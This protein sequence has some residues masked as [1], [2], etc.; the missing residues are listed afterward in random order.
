MQLIDWIVL[1]GTLTFIVTYGVYKTRN[2]KGAQDYIRGGSETRWW[3]IGL[4]TMATQA[5]AITFLSTPGQAFHDGMG[6]VQ[7]YFGLP[8]AMVIICMFFIPIYRRLNVYTAYEYLESRFDRKTRTL[9]AV[10]FLIQRG[11]AAGL[12]I[13]APAIIL[14]AVLGW[15]LSGLTVLIGSL[16]IIYTVAGGTKAVSVTHKQQMA[17]ILTGMF[18]AFF[19]ILSYLPENINFS[20]A[21]EIAG[22][23]GKMDILDFSFD[24]ENRYTF[25]SGII[26]GSFLALSYFGT[27]QS[28]VQRYLSGRSVNES[29]MGMIMNGMLKVPLQFFILLVGVLVFVFYQFNN[30]P[31]NFNPAATETVL[32]SDY[33]NQY[34]D[35]MLE[36]DEIQQEKQNLHLQFAE[37]NNFTPKNNSTYRE[38]LATLNASENETR[39]KARKLI[40]ASDKDAESNDKDYVFIHFILN[41]L[42]RGLIGLL[43]AVILSAA[44]SSTASE[45]NA[46]SSTTSID[47]YKRSRKTEMSDEHYVKASKWFTLLWGAIAIAFASFANLFDNLIQLVNIIGSIFYG[48]VLGIF[49]LAFFIKIVNS[50][51]VFVAAIITQI[52]VIILYK[53]DVMPYL[54]LNL[55][56]CLLVMALALILELFIKTPEHKIK[57]ST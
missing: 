28:Q 43:L 13:F 57:R 27:D 11:L 15:N 47:L 44:M 39:Q 14:S 49:L 26:G 1:L 7:F 55:V 54:W 56:G 29:R 36:H 21:L 48:N 20:N 19:I 53:F 31:L 40:D 6:F 9:T 45:L 30:A 37:N 18:A 12:T 51:S 17:V 16:V 23:S 32:N 24:F 42:P 8:I 38:N 52:I 10:L 4:S 33:G 22:A 50:N 46:L 41:N 2:N 3:T 35:L 25:W 34:E 5:S